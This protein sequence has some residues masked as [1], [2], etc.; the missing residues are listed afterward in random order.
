MSRIVPSKDRPNDYFLDIFTGPLFYVIK[1]RFALYI[2]HF[3]EGDWQYKTK[4]GYP[5][6]L[7]ACPNTYMENKLQ[8]YIKDKLED[9]GINELDIYTTTAN[10]LLTSYSNNSGIWTKVTLD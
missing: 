10:A 2:D 4:R 9:A 6:M 1:K 7:L 8:N 5:A 3:D